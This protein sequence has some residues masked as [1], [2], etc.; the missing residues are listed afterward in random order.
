MHQAA[1]LLSLLIAGTAHSAEVNETVPDQFQGTW[2]GSVAE[3]S[4]RAAESRFVLSEK[5]IAFWESQGPVLAVASDREL[6]L[7]LIVELSAEGQTWLETRQFRLSVDR[8]TLSDVTGH[9][10]PVTRVRCKV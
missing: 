2:A 10:L 7:A 6:E 1:I 4:A 8:N 9:Q 3:C 5:R